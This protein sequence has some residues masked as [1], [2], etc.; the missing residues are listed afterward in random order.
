MK[1]QP[2]VSIRQHQT[3]SSAAR[4]VNTHWPASL[5]A[6]DG[7]STTPR[8]AQLLS[9][10][11][12]RVVGN[13][14][15]PPS[16]HRGKVDQR[17]NNVQRAAPDV[18]GYL[19]HPQSAADRWA[20]Q[21]SLLRLCMCCEAQ[22]YG[23]YSWSPL[24]R[25][26]GSAKCG[27][28][29]LA[30]AESR[31]LQRRRHQSD[32][33]RSC[34]TRGNVPPATMQRWLGGPRNE[35]RCSIALTGVLPQLAI[36]CGP[37]PAST[38]GIVPAPGP[39]GDLRNDKQPQ[40]TQS[41]RPSIVSLRMIRNGAT[42]SLNSSADAARNVAPRSKASPAARQSSAPAVPLIRRPRLAHAAARRSHPQIGP[43]RPSTYSAGCA[44]D[45]DA[46][47]APPDAA[48]LY[49]YICHSE[50]GDGPESQLRGM[51]LTGLQQIP[52]FAGSG[53]F[54]CWQSAKPRDG[55]NHEQDVVPTALRRAP[56]G[57]DREPCCTSPAVVGC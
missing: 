48:S 8:V 49:V 43:R 6:S 3:A 4:L 38:A 10:P 12:C 44:A 13:E 50:G 41:S 28:G 24:P 15:A 47:A 18:A 57:A 39:F 5:P 52:Q 11:R 56:I 36:V 19:C 29:S 9:S 55:I 37:N 32:D 2:A 27:P 33:G 22:S 25:Q 42:L 30:A 20:R 34:C 46:Q 31:H 21:Q 26:G 7:L 23:T 1:C 35:L 45:G 40:A 14:H 16:L 53:G 54:C 17:R 51:M